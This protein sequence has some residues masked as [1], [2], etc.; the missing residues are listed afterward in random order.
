MIDAHHHLWN[1]AVRAYPWLDPDAHA[2]I[3]RAYALDDLRKEAAAHGVTATV[4]VQTVATAA[5]TADFL[6]TARAS[7]GLIAGV[8]GWTDLTAPEPA[9]PDAPL[10]VG[11]RHQVEDEPDP[12]W[13]VRAD[14]LRSLAALGARGLVYDLLVRAPQRQAALECVRGLDEVPFVLDHAG[15]PGIAAGE[16]EPW[17]SWIASMAA[18][19]NTVCKLSGLVT[20]A[21][22]HTWT[23]GLLRPYAEHVLAA[24]GADRILFGS[25]WPVCELAGGYAAVHALT[26]DLLRSCTATERAAVLGDTARR[27]YGLD[28]G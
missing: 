28:A 12:R 3:H 5:E 4:L 20:E 6:A 1:P 27:V 13:L 8:V 24:F 19:E 26:D 2:P 9:L 25:D 22:W 17:A 15:K 23:A 7:G 16:W 14:V 21:P 10:L 18:C 11:V